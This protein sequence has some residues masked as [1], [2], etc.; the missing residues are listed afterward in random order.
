M[1]DDAPFPFSICTFFLTCPHFCAISV[2]TCFLGVGIVAKRR[3]KNDR[4]QAKL[5]CKKEKK[6][7]SQLTAVRT[8]FH[9]N[10]TKFK[11]PLSFIGY[12]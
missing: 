11:M 7:K 3:K 10:T 1:A 5:V 9:P 12:K 6:K 2:V 8:K 4:Y